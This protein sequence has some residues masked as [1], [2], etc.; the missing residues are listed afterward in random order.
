M[1]SPA[2]G[3]GTDQLRMEWWLDAPRVCARMD[4]GQRHE[5]PAVALHE[6]EVLT[7]TTLL[8]SGVRGLSSVTNARSKAHGLVEIPTSFSDVMERDREAALYWRLRSR[9][10]LASVFAEGYV[11]VG[12]IRQANRSFLHVKKGTRAS[13]LGER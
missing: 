12:M 6:M 5:P 11:A 10:V 8:P 3:T 2:T 1:L 13:E 9:E 7:N 4:Q